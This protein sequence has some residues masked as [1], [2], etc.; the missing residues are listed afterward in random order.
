MCFFDWGAEEEGAAGVNG[1]WQ[2]LAAYTETNGQIPRLT[3]WA[4]TS[5]C[6]GQR[7]QGEVLRNRHGVA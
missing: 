4:T 3:Y 6:R 1:R 2:G 7:Y 5:G